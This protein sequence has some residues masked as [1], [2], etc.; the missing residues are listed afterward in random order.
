MG[1]WVKGKRVGND[2]SLSFLR[3]W[4]FFLGERVKPVDSGSDEA[5]D[6]DNVQTAP[7]ELAG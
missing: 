4:V 6:D 1:R 5:V 3:A 7:V 2:R